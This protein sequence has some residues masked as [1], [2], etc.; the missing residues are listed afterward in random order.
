MNLS[1]RAGVVQMGLV[2]GVLA[3]AGFGVLQPPPITQYTRSFEFGSALLGLGA[4]AAITGWGLSAGSRWGRILALLVAI[5]AAFA[6]LFGIYGLLS[7]V[8]SPGLFSRSNVA[9]LAVLL[10]MGM[11]SLVL[12]FALPGET[13]R[14]SEPSSFS[15]RRRLT[16]LATSFVVGVGASALFGA[17]LST[18]PEPPCCPA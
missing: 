4:L 8:A 17:V 16:L 2:T 14:M 9:V 11:T 5:A 6:G 3:F 15:Q 12:V 10:F 18:M 13:S 1:R 7:M